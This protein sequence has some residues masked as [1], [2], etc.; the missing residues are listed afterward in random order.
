MNQ[1]FYVL[2]T[3]CFDL[4]LVEQLL[5]NG[6]SIYYDID[7]LLNFYFFIRLNQYILNFHK[8]KDTFYFFDRRFLFLTKSYDYLSFLT[9]HKAKF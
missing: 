2:W 4:I 9:K 6:K 8:G 5:H 3:Q 7:F 1:A